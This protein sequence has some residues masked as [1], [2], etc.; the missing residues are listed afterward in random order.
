MACCPLTTPAH[1][2]LQ[3]DILSDVVKNKLFGHE[4]KKRCLEY[5]KMAQKH[6][7]PFEWSLATQ[8]ISY[9]F[10]CMP[11]RE[12]P[13]TVPAPTQSR[14]A[15]TRQLQSGFYFKLSQNRSRTSGALS[16]TCLKL[17]SSVGDDPQQ[18]YLS[19]PTGERTAKNGA[20]FDVKNLPSLLPKSVI[21][22]Q[23]EDFPTHLI[24]KEMFCTEC[25]TPLSDPIIITQ[26]ARIVTFCGTVEG[27]FFLFMHWLYLCE[28]NIPACFL[29]SP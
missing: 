21:R 26:K 8:V 11:G 9:T 1:F 13:G 22:I 7:A 19:A 12:S 28:W 24:P 10:P 4:K 2:Y 29:F 23:K 20:V 25:N 3:E 18:C 17:L 27:V 14:P 16:W 5:Q 15:S 6:K